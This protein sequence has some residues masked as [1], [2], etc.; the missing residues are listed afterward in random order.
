VD[1]IDEILTKGSLST[2]TPS[3]QDI[4]DIT[5]TSD[6]EDSGSALP[7]NDIH[8]SVKMALLLAKKTMNRYYGRSDES[9]V[10]RISM[11]TSSMFYCTDIC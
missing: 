10:Y 9:N 3:V 4:Y 2:A 1:K 11:G 8:P 7:E 6:D 5:L